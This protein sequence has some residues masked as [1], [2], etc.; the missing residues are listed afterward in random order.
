MWVSG[1]QDSGSI[2]DRTTYLSTIVLGIY[3]TIRARQ[4]SIIVEYTNDLLD[5]MRRHNVLE[6]QCKKVGP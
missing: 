6:Q 2:P 4:Q 5:R 1:T 3:F